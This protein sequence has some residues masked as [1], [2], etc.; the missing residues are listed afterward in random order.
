MAV[1]FTGTKELKMALKRIGSLETAKKVVRA[2]GAELQAKAQRNAP[3]D[4]GNLKRS[5]GLEVRD[6]GFTAEVAAKAKYAAYQE[7]GTRFIEA[8]PFMKP[9]FNEQKEKF[10]RDMDRLAK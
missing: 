5:I 7:Y 9:A 4:T 2:N 3:V 10:K 8:H 1:R 6:A